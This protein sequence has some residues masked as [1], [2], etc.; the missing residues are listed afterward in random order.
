MQ[1]ILLTVHQ[2]PCIGFFVP[3]DQRAHIAAKSGVAEIFAG[4]AALFAGVCLQQ[5]AAIT[6]RL[7]GEE[8]IERS[9]IIAAHF[10]AETV[11]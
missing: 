5:R 3:D 8:D 9:M 7:L 10:A 6:A 1:I 11:G 2:L 4:N